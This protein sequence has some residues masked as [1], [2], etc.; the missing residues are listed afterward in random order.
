MGAIAEV[1][2]INH[3]IILFDGVCNFCAGSVRFIIQRDT[4]ENFRFASLQSGFS[5]DLIGATNLTMDT[6]LL[7]EGGVIYKESTAAL[8]IARRLRGGWKL[9]YGL[10]V[11]PKF[12]RDSI[13][14]LI[15]R[16]RYRW[17]GKK[18]QCMVP[19]PELQARFL[20]SF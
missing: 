19:S 9:L 1:D 14:R 20:D 7:V 2:N 4:K 16:N 8:R 10:I 18:D 17:F 5:K 3:P 15:A 6:L 11:L 12:I 13:Y